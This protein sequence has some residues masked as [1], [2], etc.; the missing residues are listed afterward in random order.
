MEDYVSQCPSHLPE[1][2]QAELDIEKDWE[3]DPPPHLDLE[4]L[5]AK[6]AELQVRPE[7]ICH[8]E[9][10]QICMNMMF[11]PNEVQVSWERAEL[12]DNEPPD[13][14]G[15]LSTTLNALHQGQE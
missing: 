12:L 3:P 15:E 6:S 7:R 2:T 8:M 14:A 5:A 9:G 11:G 10:E 13:W 1:P 4:I